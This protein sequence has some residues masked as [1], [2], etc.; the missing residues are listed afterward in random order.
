MVGI[1]WAEEG[2]PV[3]YMRLPLWVEAFRRGPGPL[4]ETSSVRPQKHRANA[5]K[6]GHRIENP[7]TWVFLVESHILAALIL[8]P[9]RAE[10][11][12]GRDPQPERKHWPEAG[13]WSVMEL[14]AG[15]LI[16]RFL[17]EHLILMASVF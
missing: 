11:N 7:T 15:N 14:A 10:R 4:R 1:W 12:G 13:Y 9:S 6:V 3:T 17:P 8:G 2:M 5:A 16:H